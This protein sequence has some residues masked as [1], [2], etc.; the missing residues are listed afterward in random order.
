MSEL[1]RLL[2]GL[3]ADGRPLSLA[4]HLD[5]HGE[6]P[7]RLVPQTILRAVEE[8]GLRGRGG[9][10]FPTA[11]KLRAVAGRRGRKVVLAN[12]AEG[13][14]TSGKDRVLLR[15]A[16]QLVLDGV[17]LAAA[18]VGADEAIVAVPRAATAELAAL[19][20][21]VGRRS[22]NDGVALRLAAVPDT[23][24]AGEE[25][26]LVN[27]VAG[28][29]ALPTSTPPRPFEKGIG[30]KP[31]LVQ[32]VETLAHL[33]LIARR[34]PAWFRELGTHDEPGSALVTLSGAVRLP[35][36]YEVALGTPL[37]DLVAQ[38]GGTTAP[39]R[40][41]LVGGYFG[42]WLDA[43]TALAC[44]LSDASL[45]AAGGMLGARAVVVLPHGSC[46]VAELAR[47]ARYL[48]DESAGQCGPCVHGLAA[49]AGATESLLASDRSDDDLRIR[50]W[51][52]QI[53]GRGGCHHPDGAA[54]FVES[55]LDVFAAEV[56]RHALGRPCDGHD[57][58][59]L[60]VHRRRQKRAA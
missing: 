48:A 20:E 15:Y 50:R 49:V 46:A 52:E 47:V 45:A 9:A 34:G 14:P 42:A 26:A 44:D 13:E 7:R 53:R 35:G 60:P 11:V 38:A 32:N 55:A 6:L 30:G 31:T 10:G 37:R 29:P 8:G 24:V 33:A 12:G 40:A 21:A 18:A 19:R 56:A 2:R 43:D 4:E 54:R 59:L 23:F 5:L 28:G 25:S 41:L 1:P 36:V 39:P 16:P 22:R 58:G 57:L 27:A 51:L 3:R 17:V